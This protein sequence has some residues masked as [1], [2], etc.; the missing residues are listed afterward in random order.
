ME[1]RNIE[2]S[3]VEEETEEMPAVKV[4]KHCSLIFIIYI[5]VWQSENVMTVAFSSKTVE[6]H[7]KV[8]N[9]KVLTGRL[10]RQRSTFK[11]NKKLAK[12]GK[13]SVCV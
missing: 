7:K 3:D 6:K 10:F 8:S 12:S 4:I 1:D 13:C 9:K 2:E 5:F 11:Q